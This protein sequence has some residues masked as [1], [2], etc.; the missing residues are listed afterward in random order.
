MISYKCY[1][2]AMSSD[3]PWF[4]DKVLLL[5]YKGKPSISFLKMQD[6]VI[7]QSTEYLMLEENIKR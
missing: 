2:K 4:P 6:A 7:R 1:W 3:I 5:R